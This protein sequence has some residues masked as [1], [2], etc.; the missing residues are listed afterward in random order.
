MIIE[1]IGLIIGILVLGAGI[2][3]CIR[4]RTTRNP[5]KYTQGNL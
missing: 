5:E 4:K 3:I 2:F 1:I